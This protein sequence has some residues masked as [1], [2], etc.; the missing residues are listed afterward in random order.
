MT[1]SF[2]WV[3]ALIL[4]AS[5][6]YAA[7][8]GTKTDRAS[9]IPFQE[10]AASVLDRATF[11]PLKA[12]LGTSAVGTYTTLQ[13]FYDYQ[14]NGGVNQYI[15]KDSVS[16]KIH[17]TY[18][19]AEDSLSI[20]PSR[21]VGYAVSTDEG[22]TW[23]NFS[24]VRVP[25]IRA[26]FPTLDLT[27]DLQEPVIANH[28]APVLDIQ[29]FVYLGDNTGF[30]T[31]LA[32][33][34][35]L[36]PPG[37]GGEPIW[38]FLTAT[39]NGSLILQGSLS[40]TTTGDAENHLQRTID[41]IDWQTLWTTLPG[42]EGGGGRYPG[43]SDKTGKVAYATRGGDTT[44]LN[45][46]T[47]NGATWTTSTIHPPTRAVGAETLGHWVGV[48]IAFYNGEPIVALNTSRSTDGASFFFAGSRVEVWGP[49]LG[50]KTAAPWDSLVYP[51]SMVSQTNHL[52]LGYPAIGVSGSEIVIAYNAFLNNQATAD[53]LASGRLHGE[54]F[55]VKST[56]GGNTWTLPVNITNTPQL[57]ERYPSISKYNTA[58][59]AYITWQEDTRAGSAAFT[60]LSPVSLAKQVFYKADLNAIFPANDIAALAITAPPA[61]GAVKEGTSFTPKAAFRNLGLA[62]QTSVPVTYQ[63]LGGGGSVIASAPGTIASIVSGQTLEITF[64]PLGGSLAP[65]LYQ[66]R[67]VAQLPG[68]QQTTNDTTISTINVI[69]VVTV[70]DCYVTDFESGAGGWFAALDGGAG[71]PDWT[72]GTPNKTQIN[73]AHSGVNAWVT[74]LTGPHSNGEES[75]LGSPVLDLSALPT[76]VHVEFYQNFVMESKWDG[77]VFQYSIDGGTT[78]VTV[79]QVLGTGANFNTATSTGWYNQPEDSSVTTFG[80]PMWGDSTD[81]YASNVDG[82][83]RSST[84]IPVGGQADVRLR[85]RW[86]ADA[87]VVFEGWAI[88][89][90]RLGPATATVG[91]PL[92]LGWN[93]VSNPVQRAADSV[94]QVYPNSQFPYAFA[95]STA[96]GYVQERTLR[97][98]AGYWA[99]FPAAETNSIDGQPVFAYELPVVAGWNMV[100]SVTYGVDTSTIVSFPAGLRAS[101]WFGFSGGYTPATTLLP[102]RAYWVKSS[103]DGVFYLASDCTP[104]PVPPAAAVSPLSRFNTVTITDA[105]GASQTLYF[106]TDMQG[107]VAAEMYEL[108]PAP[109]AGAFDAR[110]EAGMMLAEHASGTAVNLP[111]VLQSAA[112]PVTVTWNVTDGSYRITDA[113]GASKEM[114]STG[115][116]VLASSAITKLVISG[117]AG[118]ALPTEYALLQNYPNP[119]NPTTSIR[120]ALPTA[121]RVTVEIYNLLGQR[122]S[123]L[124]ENALAAGYHSVEWNGTG[125][126]SQL[127]GSGV[128]FV[129]FAAT[130]ADGATFSDTRKIMLMK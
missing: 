62:T 1:Q 35:P 85:W 7:P 74:K 92:T 80:V 121:S 122:V 61:G 64:A 4:C 104:G 36:T 106:G 129:R 95:F 83:I 43:V 44:F 79:D 20:S 105:D 47:D 128:Y 57:D 86:S 12:P 11:P 14:S 93:M 27:Q 98:G 8:P 42:L 30:F 82:W 17:V 116:L 77:G 48:D 16:G 110:F 40:N 21:R 23:N 45:L 101:S 63:V 99:K 13:G 107:E 28:N 112:Y 120:F 50:F 84:V 70:T 119:F 87:A 75:F 38:P 72:L 58:G 49:T 53:T 111:V 76:N 54:I 91:V 34:P 123:T 18:M 5:L 9:V 32:P 29:S 73:R 125:D 37:S 55:L 117:S 56:D 67:V 108:P 26:G 2:R 6:A 100:G 113:A 78:W 97:I 10:S 39:A 102:G 68:D 33:L 127:V 96:S 126:A 130:G 66:T 24:N 3:V 46:S 94:S 19:L 69:P 103:G 71:T 65:G 118:E 81:L 31:E 41:L 51:S 22:A 25:G 114:G 60:D 89:D 52:A 59:F 90:I 115:S 15:R 109:P 124:L 88:D